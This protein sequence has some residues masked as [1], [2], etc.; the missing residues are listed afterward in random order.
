MGVE[1]VEGGE[2]TEALD[3]EAMGVGVSTRPATGVVTD[4]MTEGR[5]AREG[6]PG[7][8]QR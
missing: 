5:I 8:L 3:V 2:V 1:G 4:M 7:I 6:F